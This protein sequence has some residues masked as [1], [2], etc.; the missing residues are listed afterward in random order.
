MTSQIVNK[1]P[2]AGS[3]S[4]ETGVTVAADGQA[5]SELPASAPAAAGDKTVS[6]RL[7]TITTGRPGWRRTVLV[8]KKP[9]RRLSGNR[10][11]SSGQSDEVRAT[12]PKKRHSGGAKRKSVPPIVAARAAK[13]TKKPTRR[14]AFRLRP[15][16]DE[17]LH[18][19]RKRLVQQ[20]NRQ[21][22]QV[23]R[24]KKSKV[25][26]AKP[27]KRLTRFVPGPVGVIL[28]YTAKVADHEATGDQKVARKH[29]ISAFGEDVE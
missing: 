4:S 23:I 5:H 2:P 20:L 11:A 16:K 17:T 9:N 25:A 22:L 12:K 28:D 8:E 29:R 14:T 27:R 15:R 19:W 13:K 3:L 24:K 10:P 1:R 26:A 21:P 18:E 6:S 7:T